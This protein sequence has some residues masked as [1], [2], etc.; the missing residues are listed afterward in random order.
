[1]GSLSVSKSD[2]RYVVVW[3]V[4]GAWGSLWGCRVWGGRI[5]HEDFRFTCVFVFFFVFCHGILF[6]LEHCRDRINA[7]L[8]TVSSQSPSMYALHAALTVSINHHQ[9]YAEPSISLA[10]LIPYLLQVFCP[11]CRTCWEACWISCTA[12]AFCLSCSWSKS[13]KR[14]AYIPHWFWSPVGKW[15]SWSKR[16]AL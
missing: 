11:S 1:M 13:E 4:R 9:R 3:L 8:S 5:L 6:L 14:S 10:R 12:C 2:T 15:K 16:S 7:C